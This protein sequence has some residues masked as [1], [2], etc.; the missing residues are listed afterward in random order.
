MNNHLNALH[1]FEN[2]PGRGQVKVKQ[3]HYRPGVAQR[4]PGS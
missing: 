4:V 2:C 3:P 1:H